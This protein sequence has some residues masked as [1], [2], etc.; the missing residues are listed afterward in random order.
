MPFRI[1]PPR[2]DEDALRESLLADGAA[3]RDVADALAEHKALKISQKNPDETVL[4]CDQVLE[5][6]GR[7]FSKPADISD[8][9]RQ[10]EQLAGQSH[11]LHSA[12]V[13]YR[14][15]QP[16]WRHVS[17]V[18]MVMRPLTPAQIV[19]YLTRAWPDV[20]GCVG[21]YQV[22]SQGVRLFSHVDGDHFAIQGLPLTELLNHL[23]D[24]KDLHP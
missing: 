7:L 2:L 12:A 15:G 8:A 3:P 24:R 18:R 4:G 23:I 20:A 1:V 22:E 16:Q 21:G 14:A 11:H 13:L 17:T 19:T 6:N 5:L 9:Q 10:L